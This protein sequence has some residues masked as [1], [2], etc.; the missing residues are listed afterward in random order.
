MILL[1]IATFAVV[2]DHLIALFHLQLEP[3]LQLRVCMV[4]NK[5]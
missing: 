2:F 4:D 5:F 1:P 3:N